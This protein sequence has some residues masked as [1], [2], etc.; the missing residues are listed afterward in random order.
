MWSIKDSY[1]S[2]LDIAQPPSVCDKA[3]QAT[4]KEHARLMGRA[5]RDVLALVAASGRR[6]MATFMSL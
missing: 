5:G 6:G 4:A 3:K 2:W 1:I